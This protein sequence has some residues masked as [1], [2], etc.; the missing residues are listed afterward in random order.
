MSLTPG[1]LARK[2]PK[3][4]DHIIQGCRSLDV[5]QFLCELDD[6]SYRRLDTLEVREP[7]L[8]L[9]ARQCGA[10]RRWFF[11]CPCCE[12]RCEYLFAVPDFSRPI[13]DEDADWRCRVCGDLSTG[14][15]ASALGTRFDGTF[16]HAGS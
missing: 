9:V 15:S 8:T 16:R 14:V 12:R 4:H 5:R 6:E 3:V 11:V 10:A 1:F 2:F 13:A 7:R